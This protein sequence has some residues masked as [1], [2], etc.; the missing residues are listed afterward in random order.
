M[1]DDPELHESGSSQKPNSALDHRTNSA[2]SRDRCVEQ[3]AAAFRKSRMKSRPETASIEFGATSRKPSS[4]ATWRRSMSKFTPASAPAPSGSCPAACSAKGKRGEA[5]A[6]ARDHPE[7][8]KQMMAEVHGLRT[9][10]MGVAGH[11]P[12]KVL[13]GTSREHPHQ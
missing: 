10:Q 11:R 1:I 7:V 2:P 3:V 6:V 13:L 12:V 4:S 9:L 8:G 5:R